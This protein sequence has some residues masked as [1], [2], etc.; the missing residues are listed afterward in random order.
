MESNLTDARRRH[1]DELFVLIRDG[2]AP[3]KFIFPTRDAAEAEAVREFIRGRKGNAAFI[4]EVGG[5]K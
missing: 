3:P 5:L 2:R 4:V 1:I